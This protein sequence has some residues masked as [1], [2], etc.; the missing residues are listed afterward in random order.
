MTGS[1]RVSSRRGAQIDYLS[2]LSRVWRPGQS[3]TVEKLHPGYYRTNK[4]LRR[5]TIGAYPEPFSLA[6][7]RAE[8]RD[9]LDKASEGGTRPP[10]RTGPGAH[11]GGAGGALVE[12]HAKRKKRSW[13]DDARMIRQ[14]LDGWRDR[15]V[16]RFDGP[17]CASA[18]AASS[19]AA[20][21]CWRIACWRS[22]ARC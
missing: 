13:R 11:V 15:P 10:S 7:G 19:T 3:R 8:A 2:I 1:S 4:R 16:R 5:L 6:A 12:R 21:P 9:A 20:R 17:T 18:G 22:S 14:E